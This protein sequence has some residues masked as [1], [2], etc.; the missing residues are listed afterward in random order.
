MSKSTTSAADTA[1][2]KG[3]ILGKIS[4][5]EGE[6]DL[7]AKNTEIQALNNRTKLVT[8]YLNSIDR[9]MGEDKSLE[10]K[11]W[12]NEAF[13]GICVVRVDKQIEI[14]FKDN[15]ANGAARTSAID[16]KLCPPIKGQSDLFSKKATSWFETDKH[17]NLSDEA[18][19][20]G[21][22]KGADDQEVKIILAKMNG[23]YK[24]KTFYIPNATVMSLY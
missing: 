24:S 9:N 1:P 3:T 16:P 6:A 2:G 23:L 15:G 8:N 14:G 12:Y 22:F 17:T 4:K 19:Y 20:V 10:D 18:G 11:T 5:T 21:S 13:D 7:L